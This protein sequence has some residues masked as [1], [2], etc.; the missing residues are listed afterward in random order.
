MKPPKFNNQ[1]NV[2]RLLRLASEMR[3]AGAELKTVDDII[4][5]AAEFQV[6][7][8][9]LRKRSGMPEYVPAADAWMDG[10]S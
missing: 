5:A 1:W 9:T 7:V 10:T 3:A 8:R 2:E 4:R 6:G